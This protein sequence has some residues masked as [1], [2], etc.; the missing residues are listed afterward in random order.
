MTTANYSF[1]MLQ[2]PARGNRRA[3]WAE[4]LNS[5][6]PV[7]SDRNAAASGSSP[8]SV[9]SGTTRANAGWSLT[10]RYYPNHWIGVVLWNDNRAGFEQTHVH[11]TT[12]GPGHHHSAYSGVPPTAA[13]INANDDLFSAA[14]DSDALMVHSG[15]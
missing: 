6:A 2:L 3:E 1:A 4:T 11:A 15:N 8:T 12:Y 14:S 7:L 13:S 9:W 5:D 10:N